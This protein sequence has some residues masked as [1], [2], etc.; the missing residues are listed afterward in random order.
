M[1]CCECGEDSTVTGRGMCPACLAAREREA[2]RGDLADDADT[3]ALAERVW[4]EC[5]Q[6]PSAV[7]APCQRHG[8]D[9]GDW[10]HL[11]HEMCTGSQHVAGGAVVMC[12]CECHAKV[13]QPPKDLP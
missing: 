6:T 2:T 1:K 10:W 12:A 4:R 5:D 13:K 11:R 7:L 8:T 9:P 3:L